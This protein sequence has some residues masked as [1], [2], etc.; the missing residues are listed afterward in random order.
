MKW[1]AVNLRQLPLT[2]IRNN[3]IFTTKLTC[4]CH[5]VKSYS[6]RGDPTDIQ[7]L[8]S[9]SKT[10]YINLAYH[11]GTVHFSFSLTIS[12]WVF[13]YIFYYVWIICMSPTCPQFRSQVRGHGCC[14]QY[15]RS[16][17]FFKLHTVL[18]HRGCCTLNTP[19]V[20]KMWFPSAIYVTFVFQGAG[21]YTHTQCISKAHQARNGCVEEEVLSEVRCH[22]ER[23]SQLGEILK[24]VLG[25][26]AHGG[27]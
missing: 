14:H 10:N 18:H 4:L 20:V 23:H 5:R 27:D 13:E 11:R 7:R 22:L 16:Q 3:L 19:T 24:S 17:S 21:G 26:W 9:G 1:A 8:K 15:Q 25:H 12:L 2:D 6:P